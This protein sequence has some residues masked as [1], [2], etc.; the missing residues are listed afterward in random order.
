MQPFEL[1][2]NFEGRKVRL[3][4]HYLKMTTIHREISIPTTLTDVKSQLVSRNQL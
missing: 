1:P 3:S 4:K 2:R